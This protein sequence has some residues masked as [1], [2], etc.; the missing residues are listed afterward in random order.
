MSF[1]II[2]I[3]E[4]PNANS[5]DINYFLNHKFANIKLFRLLTLDE[6]TKEGKC[7]N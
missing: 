3:K 5:Q 6:L 7:E 2:I 4:F 1:S